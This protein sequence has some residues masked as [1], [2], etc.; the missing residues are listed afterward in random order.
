[1]CMELVSFHASVASIES[2]RRKKKIHLIKET[3]LHP[4]CVMG[5]C[6]RRG[7]YIVLEVV[8]G[9]LVWVFK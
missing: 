7:K 1:M 8:Q 5:S 9:S 6:V 2:P 3:C 4:R